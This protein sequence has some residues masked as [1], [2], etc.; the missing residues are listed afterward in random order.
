M[1]TNPGFSI[2]AD[3]A[4]ALLPIPMLWKVQMNRRVKVAVVVVLSLGLWYVIP[5]GNPESCEPI[6]YLISP[7]FNEIQS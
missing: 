3:L 2:F 7:H 1:L 4:M 5:P 6:L